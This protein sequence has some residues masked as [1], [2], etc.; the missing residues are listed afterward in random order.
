MLLAEVRVLVSRVMAAT[1]DGV[2]Q[3]DTCTWCV[4]VEGDAQPP[5]SL[6]A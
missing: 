3:L 1:R 2:L 4:L 6:A 5:C